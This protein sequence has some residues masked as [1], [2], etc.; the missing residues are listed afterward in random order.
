MVRY[1]ES[2]VRGR[3]GDMTHR[4][5]GHKVVDDAYPVTLQELEDRLRT[6]KATNPDFP[7][8]LRGDAAVQY[9]KVVEVL[10]I[11]RR[12]ELAQVGLVTGKPK[13]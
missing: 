7:V 9:Q 13:N 5:L 11:L 2:D 10:D 1:A 6:E 8:V 12:L 3:T 4:H